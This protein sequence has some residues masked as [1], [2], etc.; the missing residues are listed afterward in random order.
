MFG[1][2]FTN[3]VQRWKHLRFLITL[4]NPHIY[5]DEEEEEGSDSEDEDDSN[6]SL[7]DEQ[8]QSF[9][10]TTYHF[11]EEAGKRRNVKTNLPNSKTMM[12]KLMR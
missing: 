10:M 9:K 1:K 4:Y 12:M 3:G 2:K 11:E 7:N 5:I 8:F 6:S